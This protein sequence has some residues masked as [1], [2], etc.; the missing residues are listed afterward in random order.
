MKNV[1]Y[2]V[3]VHFDQLDG[4]VIEAK[5]KLKAGQTGF[6]KHGATL[7]FPFGEY[8]ILGQSTSQNID[9]RI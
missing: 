6:G 3:D 7:L 4:G 5:R 8:S 2:T 9:N 1:P